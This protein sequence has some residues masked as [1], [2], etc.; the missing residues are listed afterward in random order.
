M[1][2]NGDASVTNV[3]SGLYYFSNAALTFSSEEPDTTAFDVALLGGPL[4]GA[5]VP[6][7]LMVDENALDDYYQWDSINYEMM[8]DSL[9]DFVTTSGTI[10]AGQRSA[11]FQVVFYP[12]KIDPTKNYMLPVTA[13]AGG[14]PVSDNYGRIYF[15]LIGNPLAGSYDWHYDRY[16]NATSTPPTS[17]SWDDVA[18]FLPDNPTTVQVQS[19]YGLQNGFNV[20][21]KITFDQDPNTGELENV[22]VVINPDDVKN[23]LTPSSITLAQNA[24]VLIMDLPNKHFKFSFQVINSAGGYRTLYDEFTAQ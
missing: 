10:E 7:T 21:Y 14:A 22:V 24:Q 4:T 13:D 1:I 18:T 2:W 6:V 19:G 8:P 5:D 3:N 9:Y 12:A 23:S 11:Q 17:I 15:H 16:N 20:R